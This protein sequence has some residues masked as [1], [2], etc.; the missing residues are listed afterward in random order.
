MPS[1]AAGHRRGM[2]PCFALAILLLALDA[3]GATP[4]HTCE[5]HPLGAAAACAETA[6]LLIVQYRSPTAA[7][8]VEALDRGTLGVRWRAAI[9]HGENAWQ[10]GAG[11]TSTVVFYRGGT[12]WVIEARD[13]RDGHVRWTSDDSTATGIYPIV[14]CDGM[15]VGRDVASPARARL[16]ALDGAT[17]KVAWTR[18]LDELIVYDSLACAGDRIVHALD[19]RGL[20]VLGA[21]D[22][23]ERSRLQVPDLGFVW[24]APFQPVAA[25]GSTFV[26]AQPVSD[27]RWRLI[28]VDLDRMRVA[29]D[30]PGAGKLARIFIDGRGVHARSDVEQ[31]FRITDGAEVERGKAVHVVIRGRMTTDVGNAWVGQD[32][33]LGRAVATTDA[34][35]RYRIEADLECPVPLRLSNAWMRK[36]P[37]SQYASATIG[38]R[39]SAT[40]PARADT[41]TIDI[42][43]SCGHPPAR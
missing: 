36:C 13:A 41:Y 5:D 3:R 7:L 37:T 16:V 9:G 12:G 14:A 35:G 40:V 27:L 8:S 15:V 39:E 24:T 31:T 19:H 43:A 20:V 34:D 23:V 28:A 4:L 6:D 33:T 32:V 17:G 38:G 26:W 30:R 21:R 11:D 2:K 25:T 22:G 1:A 29:W 10:L 18:S 42:V